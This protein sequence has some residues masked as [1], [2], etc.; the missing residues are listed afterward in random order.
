[1]IWCV[2]VVGKKDKSEWI[3]FLEKRD[4]RVGQFQA[5]AGKYGGY[6][7]VPTFV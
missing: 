3:S 2:N 1:L 7:H 6:S 4:F 5:R